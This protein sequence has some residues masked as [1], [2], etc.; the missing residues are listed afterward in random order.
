VKAGS[1]Q[2]AIAVAEAG[3]KEAEAALAAVRAGATDQEI[4][5]AKAGVEEARAGLGAAQ[6]AY[7]MAEASL[8]DYQLVAPYASTVARISTHLGEFVSPSV[9]V[10]SLGNTADW[11]VETDDLTEIDVVQVAVG[12]PVKVTIDAIPGRDFSG[13]VTEIAPRSETKRGD[14]TYTVTIKLNDANNAP[15]RWGLTAFV[16]INVD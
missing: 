11:Y 7:E 16:D 15:L 9:P 13:V 5:I 4:A 8:A 2:E 3:V 1:S 14:V 6:A 10:V 12:Q